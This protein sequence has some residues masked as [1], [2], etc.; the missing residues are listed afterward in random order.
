[1]PIYEF[2][3]QNCSYEFEKIQS[4]SVTTV[5]SCPRCAQVQVQRRL[6]TPAIHFKGSGWYINDS[7]N[8]AKS[9]TTGKSNGDTT[10]DSNGVT[11]GDNPSAE[12]SSVES[13]KN[14]K[15]TGSEGTANNKAEGA[16]KSEATPAKSEASKPEGAKSDKAK[17]EPMPAK[18]TA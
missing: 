13:A 9:S 7:K 8:S 6:S 15:D 18:S 10:G 1:M 12:G 5:P 4:F 11:N 3:C 16:S 17:T 14:S 2:V